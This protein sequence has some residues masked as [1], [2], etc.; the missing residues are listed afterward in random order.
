MPIAPTRPENLRD[1]YEVPTT[2]LACNT[3]EISA[4][5][6]GNVLA[7]EVLLAGSEAMLAA[8]GPYGLPRGCHSG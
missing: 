4:F 7:G 5:E 3:S 8:T 1:P 6:I 2:L